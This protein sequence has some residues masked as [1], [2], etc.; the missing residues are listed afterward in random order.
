V[1]TLLQI[2]TAYFLDAE[3]P[4]GEHESLPVLRFDYEG[5]NGQWTCFVHID[6]D[7]G[8]VAVYSVL[9]DAVPMERLGAAGAVLAGA[10]FQLPIGA[11]EMDLED[12]EVRFRASI[13]VSQSALTA[14]LLDPLVK[15]NWVAVDQYLPAL[16]A[17][18]D[19]AEPADALAAA[20]D[21]DDDDSDVDFVL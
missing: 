7:R 14:G 19:G 13:D 21:D 1:S 10:N 2:A 5:D 6:D 12:G 15:A 11:F 18:V 17:V 16:K 3:I 20:A 8:H 4:V 9:P